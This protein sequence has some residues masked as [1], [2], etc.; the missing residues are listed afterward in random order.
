MSLKR[1]LPASHRRAKL[2]EAVDLDLD[3]DVD[4][5]AELLDGVRELESE[6]AGTPRRRPGVGGV[7]DLNVPL[8]PGTLPKL[9]GAANGP[10]LTRVQRKTE[11]SPEERRELAEVRERFQ[12]EKP[13]MEDLLATGDYTTPE[14]RPR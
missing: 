9:P 5:N 13:T 1:V 10:R 7:E 11:R 6:R 3:L 4:V 14:E 12:R 2:T 8:D